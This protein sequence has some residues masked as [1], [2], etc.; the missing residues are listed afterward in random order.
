[1]QTT[2]AVIGPYDLQIAA[3][4][5]RHGL[6]VVTSNVAEFSRVP[7]LAIEDWVTGKP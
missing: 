1:L 6:T 7:G 4:A 3:I 2:G 5:V